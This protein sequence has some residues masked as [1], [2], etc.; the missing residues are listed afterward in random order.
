MGYGYNTG[1]VCVLTL[2]A[3]GLL[4]FC[5]IGAVQVEYG[6]SMGAVLVEYEWNKGAVWVEY[7]CSMGT[8]QV[9]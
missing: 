1:A 4:T 2:L 9:Q 6:W 3:F 5:S 7:G 8:V